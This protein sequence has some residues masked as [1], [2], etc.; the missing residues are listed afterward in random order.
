MISHPLVG[1]KHRVTESKMGSNCMKYN[2]VLVV[3]SGNGKVLGQLLHWSIG[4]NSSVTSVMIL[5]AELCNVVRIRSVV[6]LSKRGTPYNNYWRG[7]GE[8]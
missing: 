5:S 8:K 1:Q 6:A 4:D 2:G 3:G 7:Q